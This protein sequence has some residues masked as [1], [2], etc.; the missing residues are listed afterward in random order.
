MGLDKNYVRSFFGRLSKQSQTDLSQS[1]LRA[2]VKPMDT[3]GHVLPDLE[4]ETTS[5]TKS[6]PVA[7]SNNYSSPRISDED[8]DRFNSSIDKQIGFVERIKNY[9][10]AIL[11]K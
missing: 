9:T 10:G 7:D 3:N 1:N 11:G 2:K 5:P 6:F 4:I 8:L